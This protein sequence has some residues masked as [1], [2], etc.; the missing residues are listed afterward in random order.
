MPLNLALPTTSF[1]KGLKENLLHPPPPPINYSVPSILPIFPYN[2]HSSPFPSS[3]SVPLVFLF[4][5]PLSTLHLFHSLI[6]LIFYHNI[7][8]LSILFIK[9]YPI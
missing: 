5:Q 7:S 8:L 4:P 2:S 6:F 9:L 1:Q 3:L